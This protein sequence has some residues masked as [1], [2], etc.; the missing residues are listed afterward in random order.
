MYDT[1]FT[2]SCGSATELAREAC[3]SG[4]DRIIAFG[5]D[6]TLHE[7]LNGLLAARGNGADRTLGH[8]PCGTSNDYHKEFWG[9]EG[10]FVER[11]QRNETRVVDACRLRCRGFDGT[12]RDRFFL[13]NSSIGVV[14]QS[15]CY[16]NAPGAFNRALKRIH[17]DLAVLNVGLQSIL[18]SG[19]LD[20]A[21]LVD[22]RQLSARSPANLSIIKAR[23]FGGG[24]SYNIPAAI[25]DG[26]LHLIGIDG[27]SRWGMAAMIPHFYRGDVLRMPGVWH[28]IGTRISIS[29]NPGQ[30]VEADGEI[31]GSLPAE[32]TILPRAVRILL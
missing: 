21:I 3:E 5:G 4:Y 12:L 30:P 18:H 31:V 15:L 10:S 20:C 29:G 14:A 7:V 9:L 28:V 13:A 11:L 2:S 27:L 1:V 26:F 22:D 16:F 24:M 25:D 8:V 23:Y 32:Y 17:P 6:G 19:P